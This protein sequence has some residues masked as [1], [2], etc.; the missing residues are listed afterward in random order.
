MLEEPPFSVDELLPL[1]DAR[2]P[3]LPA[4]SSTI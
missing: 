2:S 3:R 1:L 4:T